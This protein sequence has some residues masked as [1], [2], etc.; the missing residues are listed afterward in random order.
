MKQDG[1]TRVVEFGFFKKG[2]RMK[3]IEAK[4]T[5]K[6]RKE[7]LRNTPSLHTRVVESKRAY[8]RKKENAQMHRCKD[9]EE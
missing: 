1:G 5:P 3:P 8:N 9:A 6:L 7:R 4:E 2:V